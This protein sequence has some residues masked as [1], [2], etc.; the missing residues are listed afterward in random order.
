MARLAQSAERKAL[1][2]VVVGCSPTVGVLFLGSFGNT[3]HDTK[4]Q[5]ANPQEEKMPLRAQRTA[6]ELN[7]PRKLFGPGHGHGGAMGI[8]RVALSPT[9]FFS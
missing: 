4:W 6:F 5:I 8:P 7:L 3:P 1:N 9:I 2:L